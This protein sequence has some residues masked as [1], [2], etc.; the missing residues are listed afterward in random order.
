MKTYYK[1]TQRGRSMIEMLGVLAIVGVLSAGGIAGYSMAMNSYKTQALIEKIHLIATT[2]RSTCRGNYT[3]LSN[4]VMVD[5]GKLKTEDFQNPFG[6]TLNAETETNGFV[7]SSSFP[8][9]ACTEILQTN[10]GEASVFNGLCFEG[11][12]AANCFSPSSGTF[13]ISIATTATKCKSG[14]KLIYLYFK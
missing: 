1:K 9:D 4:S 7:I 2:V 8:T 5:L 14:N 10:W 13:P 12:G 11:G 6:G 3:G